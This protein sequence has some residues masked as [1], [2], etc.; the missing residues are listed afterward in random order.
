MK[1]KQQQYFHEILSNV[2]NVQK[3][4]IECSEQGYIGYG[5]EYKKDVT[6]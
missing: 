1:G 3:P 6:I 5:I 2:W 4:N